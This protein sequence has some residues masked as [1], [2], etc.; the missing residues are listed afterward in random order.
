MDYQVT[1]GGADVW[2]KFEGGSE[3]PIKVCI[4]VYITQD[5]TDFFL[6]LFNVIIIIT[7]YTH[8]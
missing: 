2:Y 3:L 8:I 6:M 5:F 4:V 7:Y 1:T